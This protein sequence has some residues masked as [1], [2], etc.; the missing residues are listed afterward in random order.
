MG[1]LKWIAKDELYRLGVKCRIGR[2]ATC[3]VRIHNDLRVSEDHALLKWTQQ[4]AWELRDLGSKNGTYVGAHR[5]ENGERISLIPGAVFTVSGHELQLVDATEPE[6]SARSQRNG[7]RRVGEGSFLVLPS[8]DVPRITV[9]Q[10]V[11]GTW[12]LDTGTGE[13]VPVSDGTEVQVD[14]ETWELEIPGGS[15]ATLDAMNVPPSIEGSTLYFKVSLDE[16]HVQLSLLHAGGTVD[17]GVRTHHYVLLTL[18]RI[19]N[20]ER[21]LP[22]SERGWVHR[23]DLCRLLG[24]EPVALNVSIFRMRKQLQSAGIGQHLVDRRKNALRIATD[25]FSIEQAP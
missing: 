13:P 22:I 17:L 23:D 15:A 16:E 10:D 25:R 3:D 5:L 9:F 8:P 20:T 18:A 6:L 4:G 12:L 19:R 21:D 14:G 24:I 7:V 2:S 11:D 1:A